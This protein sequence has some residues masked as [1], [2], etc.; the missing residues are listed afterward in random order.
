MLQDNM[1]NNF[2]YQKLCLMRTAMG[3]PFLDVQNCVSVP[4]SV[5]HDICSKMHFALQYGQSKN[6][7]YI[8]NVQ[9]AFVQA[10]MQMLKDIN[11]SNLMYAHRMKELF[12]FFEH[13]HAVEEFFPEEVRAPL[14]RYVCAI[15]IEGRCCADTCRAGLDVAYALGVRCQ[16]G[17]LMNLHA[18]YWR[19]PLHW[20]KIMAA[21]G[22]VDLAAAKIHA[23]I[24]TGRLSVNHAQLETALYDI[25]NATDDASDY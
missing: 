20:L 23:D 25:N 18:L 3:M 7:L 8:Y 24:D 11:S 9:R 6:S 16:P 21:S 22:A 19:Y 17:A 2:W 13:L 4:L 12:Y 5:S 10:H 14:G 1:Q 15:V